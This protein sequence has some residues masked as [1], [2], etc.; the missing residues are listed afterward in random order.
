[1]PTE[2]RLPAQP[3]G[4][5][6]QYQAAILSELQGLTQAV[7]ELT[8]VLAGPGQVEIDDTPLLKPKRAS[9]PK[10]T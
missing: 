1:M 9:K 5:E 3:R 2:P 4:A 7:R 8:A 6:Q 10:A